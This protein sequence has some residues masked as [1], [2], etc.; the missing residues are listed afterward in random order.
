M[1]DQ[2][3]HVLGPHDFVKFVIRDRKDF[4]IATHTKAT[5]VH[6]G[7]MARFAFSP[8][9]PELTPQ[10][11]LEWMDKEE[12]CDSILNVQLHK[13]LELKENA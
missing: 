3:F 9:N 10:L 11:L 4:A 6:R 7:C 1:N 13:L 2:N 5:L 12:L 8:V